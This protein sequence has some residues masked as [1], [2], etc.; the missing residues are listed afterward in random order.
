[1]AIVLAAGFSRRLGRPKQTLVYEGETLLDRATRIAREVADEVVVVTRENNPDAEEGMA[2]SIRAGVSLAGT[3]ARLLITLCDQP[4]VTA[5][6]LRALI[7]IDAPI[8]ATG[9]AGIA[10]VPAIFAPQF[11]PELL[12]LRGDRGARAIIETHG[13]RVVFFEDAAVDVDE[14]LSRVRPQIST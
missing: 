5:D 11:V 12:A 8:V 14:K 3:D 2:S 4:L 9:Y 13:A 6:H 1:V 7:A 10:G